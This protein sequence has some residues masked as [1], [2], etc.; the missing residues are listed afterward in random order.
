M[1]ASHEDADNKYNP[2]C[3]VGIYWRS[4]K[5]F[6]VGMMVILGLRNLVSY[7]MSEWFGMG[8]VS[9]PPA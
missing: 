1:P 6:I 9:A 5:G 3:I 2:H 8:R 7:E 4:I